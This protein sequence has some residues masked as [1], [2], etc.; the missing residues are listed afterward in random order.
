MLSWNPYEN[1]RFV[2]LFLFCCV[3][4]WCRQLYR[5]RTQFCFSFFCLSEW[6]D[7]RIFNTNERETYKHIITSLFYVFILLSLSLTHASASLKYWKHFFEWGVKL[8]NR[9]DVLFFCFI[10]DCILFVSFRVVHFFSSSFFVRFVS[11]W[12]NESPFDF[13][14]F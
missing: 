1:Y 4:K 7:K 14:L 8:E 3:W 11:N 13:I 5:A 10:S 12:F 6:D 9:T 2:R